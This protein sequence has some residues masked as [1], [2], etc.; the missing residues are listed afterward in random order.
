MADIFDAA[1][2]GDVNKELDR[3]DAWVTKEGP[4]FSA[5]SQ[6]AEAMTKELD[7]ASLDA[8]QAMIDA[9]PETT[10]LKNSIDAFV[11]KYGT[12]QAA[13]KRWSEI[14]ERLK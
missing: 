2:K 1:V 9:R 5:L 3:L 11:G 12:D 7:Q 13:M 8:L 14:L 10:R 4:R 6:K